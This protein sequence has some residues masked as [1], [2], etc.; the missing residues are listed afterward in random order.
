MIIFISHLWHG[1]V[2]H[3]SSV[4]DMPPSLAMVRDKF[5][6]EATSGQACDQNTPPKRMKREYGSSAVSVWSPNLGGLDEA[7]LIDN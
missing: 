7:P 1:I 2:A 4:C 6:G 3:A 5:S